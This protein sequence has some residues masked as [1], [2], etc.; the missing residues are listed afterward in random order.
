MMAS[1]VLPSG[2][3]AQRNATDASTV[4]ART[5]SGLGL[6]GVLAFSFSL[7]ATALAVR[8]LDPWVVAFGRAAVASLL[9]AA[10]LCAARAPRPTAAQ[11]RRL[12]LVAGGVVV[13][14]PLFTSLALTTTD[15]SHG[16]VV[17]ALLPATTALAAVARAGERPGRGFWAAAAAGLAIVLAFVVAESS[18]SFTG[19]DALLLAATVTCAVGYAE[20]GA[21]AREL[22]GARTICWALVVSFPV[23]AA[24]TVA[25]VLAAGFHAGPEALA[26]FAYVSVVSQFLG[27]F[28]WYAGL[29]LGGVA[30]VGQVQLLQPLLTIG[31]SALVLGEAVGSGTL[32]AAVG[33]LASVA[34]TQRARVRGPATI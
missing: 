33:V 16:A 17:V 8:D 21:L 7:P 20:G 32:V 15:A 27:F 23:T 30:R 3:Q 19:A 12:G 1:R 13:G 18:G 14:F 25:A 26:G 9:G 28:A 31:W 2:M 6:L 10:V 22:G 34:A 5:G 24:A 11:W 4:T 29:A